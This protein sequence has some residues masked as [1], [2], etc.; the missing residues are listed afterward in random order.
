MHIVLV[1]VRLI[2]TLV[3]FRTVHISVDNKMLITLH[4]ANS[5]LNHRGNKRN[6]LPLTA[7]QPSSDYELDNDPANLSTY[8][9][10]PALENTGGYLQPIDTIYEEIAD[11]LESVD[12]LPTKVYQR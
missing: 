1:Q 8:A 9:N 6:K 4:E 5:A 3:F 10:D 12:N 2:Q 7:K 11:S